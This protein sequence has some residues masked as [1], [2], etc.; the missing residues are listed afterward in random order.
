MHSTPTAT[1]EVLLNLIPLH[2]EIRKHAMS[3][4]LRL[5][6]NF[7]N[8][9]RF[10]SKLDICSDLIRKYP[11]LGLSSDRTV[12]RVRFDINFDT[13]IKTREF[14]EEGNSLELPPG[15]LCFYTDGSKT[16]EGSGA[17]VFGRTPKTNLSDCL[18][19]M[20]TVFQAEIHALSMCADHILGKNFSCK[21]I[22][23]FSDSQAAIKAV[24]SF[25]FES[26]L[27]WICRDRLQLVGD[28]Y[29]LKIA[30]IPGHRGHWGN[31]EADRLAKAGASATCIGPEP[32]LPLAWVTGK[33]HLTQWAANAHWN[34][35]RNLPALRQSKLFVTSLL[36]PKAE[37][38]LNLNRV[39]LRM[40]VGLM[41]GHCPLRKHLRVI[42]ARNEGAECGLCG[43]AEE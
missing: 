3:F 30:W 24:S 25:R 42:G 28:K 17:G 4:F 40:V 13:I 16:Q 43:L 10:H 26:S 32:V 6:S 12:A 20:A 14:W 29:K 34:Y 5:K 38:L 27:V 8:L 36:R 11:Y 2:L 19:K 35:F 37:K 31:E 18:G 1:M 9:F 7:N 22:Y 41:T 15:S 21:N 33:S 23:I 39:D